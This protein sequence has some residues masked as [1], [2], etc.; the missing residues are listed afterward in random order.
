MISWD[1]SLSCRK[2]I[3][4]GPTLV[5]AAIGRLELD[6]DR[7]SFL[8]LKTRPESKFDTSWFVFG[9]PKEPSCVKETFWSRGGDIFAGPGSLGLSPPND[10]QSE[11]GSPV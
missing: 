3:Y 2:G 8:Y 11:F 4:K 6:R 1:L 10:N 5:G 7:V 9:R